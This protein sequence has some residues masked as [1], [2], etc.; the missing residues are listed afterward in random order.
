[1]IKKKLS[2]SLIIILG[3]LS[4]IIIG[5]MLLLL[6]FATKNNYQLSFIDAFFT[7]TS[8]VCV[9][10]LVPVSSVYDVFT[11]FGKIVI[12]LLIE[13][14]GLGFVTIT[15]Y[16]FSIL[17]FKIGMNDRFLIK[18]SLNQNSL[19]GM[20]RLVK[21]TVSTTLIIQ[22]F[23]TLINLLIYTRDFPFFQALGI[24]AFH[25][26]SAFNNAGFD[27]LPYGNSLMF[28]QNN[29][30]L[31]INTSLLIIIGGIGFIVIEDILK[32]KR[33]KKLSIHSKIVLKTTLSLIVIGTI[34]L[35]ITEGNH[36]TWLQAF[37]SSVSAR[38]AGFQTV[39]FNS[40]TNLGLL[41]IM[42]IM[43]IGASPSSTGGGIKTTTFYTIGKYI[44][45]FAKGEQP[46]IYN[47][48]IVNQSIIKAFIL[49][50]FSISFIILMIGSISF[51][52]KFNPR[53]VDDQ[54]HYF[55]KISF[56]VVSAFGTVGNSM[57]ITANL[58]W[59]SKLLLSITMF[60]GRLGP[61]T[62]MSI[63]NRHWNVEN[64]HNVKYLEE[65][66]IV[67]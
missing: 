20:V 56:E 10:G 21:F 57:D 38:T 33:F 3:F 30:L 59:L 40:F 19:K 36:I 27:I 62:I 11:I 65:T 46:V 9:T 41:L 52:E 15:I 39:N 48:K 37:F 29:I 63:W 26:I 1:M 61:I 16:I 23:G 32:K 22:T 60:F 66:I 31:N 2:P 43:Y 28:Y 7:S 58:H 44:T 53:V 34:I 5:T 13:I 55:V 24:S 47:R 12:I 49:V 6:P 4:V 14:G 67:G 35:K 17:G 45:S 42:I 8:A 64:Y 50:V 54:Y 18:E 25:S 51:I